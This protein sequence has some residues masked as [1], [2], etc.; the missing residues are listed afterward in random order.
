MP[1]SLTLETLVAS[2]FY[3]RPTLHQVL[4]INASKILLTH[5]PQM[6][7]LNSLAKLSL[8]RENTP[9]KPVNVVELL[10]ETFMKG[11]PLTLSGTDHLAL[12][13]SADASGKYALGDGVAE[14]L[15]AELT[16]L[17]NGLIQTFEEA[18]VSFWNALTGGLDVTRLRW[19]EQVLKV[20]LLACIEQQGLEAHEKKSLHA[21]LDGDS[22]TSQAYALRVSLLYQGLSTELK[23]ADWLLIDKSSTVAT[24]LWCKPCGI[25]HGFKSEQALG[26]ALQAAMADR[27]DFDELSWSHHPL[28][29]NPFEF[30]ALQLLAGSIEDVERLELGSFERAEKLQEQLHHLSAPARHFSDLILIDEQK[31]ESVIPSWLKQASYQHQYDYGRLL[32]EW[33]VAQT[34]SHYSLVNTHVESIEQYAIRRLREQMHTDHPQQA[35]LDPNLLMITVE[36]NETTVP[37]EDVFSDVAFLPATP[38][39]ST[40]DISLA[41][42]AIFRLDVDNGEFTTKVRTRDNDQPLPDGL[43]LEY[44][45]GLIETVNIGGTYPAYLKQQLEVAAIHPGWLQDC[46]RAWRKSLLLNAFKAVTTNRLSTAGFN[47]IA[48]FCNAPEAHG[49]RLSIAPLAFQT[50]SHPNS[51]DVVAGMFVLQLPSLNR[52]LLY[53]PWQQDDSLLEF[54]AFK[55]ILEKLIHDE[56]LQASIL[57]W[58]DEEAST[59]HAIEGLAHPHLKSFLE[60]ALEF[61]SPERALLLDLQAKPQMIFAPFQGE[62]DQ[63]LYE[64]WILYLS[65]LSMARSPSNAKLRHEQW[66][67]IA[68]AIFD[69]ASMFACGWV[70]DMVVLINILRTLDRDLPALAEADETQKAG[71]F[72]D[73][74]YNAI[75]VSMHGAGKIHEASAPPE[76]T[77]FRLENKVGHARTKRDIFNEPTPSA[78]A[79]N[80]AP[81]TRLP[82][83]EPHAQA[84]AL[85][86][87]IDQQEQKLKSIESVIERGEKALPQEHGDATSLH[88]ERD[89]LA[90]HV[91]L[92]VKKLGQL[93]AALKKATQ[94]GMRASRH[95]AKNLKKLGHY[96]ARLNSVNESYFRFTRDRLTE[97]QVPDGPGKSLE[98][99]D[100]YLSALRN[101]V[102]HRLK[103]LESLALFEDAP[104]AQPGKPSP[105][106]RLFEQGM[107]ELKL[108]GDVN[109]ELEQLSILPPIT[110]H[111]VPARP[112]SSRFDEVLA[113]Q[114][115]IESS[116]ESFS[117][118]ERVEKLGEALDTYN[119]S[120][121][122]V[123]YALKDLDPWL[124]SKGLGDLLNYLKKLKRLTLRQLGETT[125]V[126]PSG[127]TGTTKPSSDHTAPAE[128]GKATPA[129]ASLGKA[130]TKHITQ[131]LMNADQAF[132]KYAK[133]Y[134]SQ[135]STLANLMDDYIEGLK[136]AASDVVAA[137]SPPEGLEQKLKLAITELQ[138]RSLALQIEARMKSTHPDVESLRFLLEHDKV[139]LRAGTTNKRLQRADDFLDVY[140]IHRRSDG[141]ELPWEAHFHYGRNVKNPL[142]FSAGHLK[143]GQSPSYQM[144]NARAIGTSQRVDLSRAVLKRATAKQLVPF[145]KQRKLA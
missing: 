97:I 42:L 63:H 126:R 54:D 58:M 81:Q 144:L 108:L 21:A 26:S 41:Q 29:S 59:L 13:T 65:R 17:L 44:L 143:S 32:L 20:A 106:Q 136:R 93:V 48:D 100:H 104:P 122:K 43:T 7:D 57:C 87:R 128:Q 60:S 25:V 30:Q 103:L 4:D 83:D 90:L 35:P 96:R 40:C 124:D 123:E 3:D 49:H 94:G 111:D 53:R 107:T 85:Q 47:T 55:G 73:L 101:N 11:E 131:M 68:W 125:R 33:V 112:L 91:F 80:R 19:M 14:S 10:L 71:A 77:A 18:Q 114:K 8:I 145:P 92:Q 24:Y 88:Q 84:E 79:G 56:K 70:G 117:E 102:K 50:G 134:G 115:A 69:V 76:P 141:S 45:Q 86:A 120:I 95:F 28:S 64:A 82:A 31:W 66:R 113:T 39:I 34:N 98:D 135:P 139:Y 74:L 140:T 121:A 132:S 138:E 6:G 62:L 78:E 1:P 130:K 118:E 127:D 89:A 75:M 51:Q 12:T 46:A 110:I 105:K 133:D 5:C 72:V 67:L 16:T 27:H 38:A 2:Q 52:W 15:N 37:V 36:A 129:P 22:V 61:L 116:P 9:A 119:A 23:L 137:A 109:E 99:Y 142:D